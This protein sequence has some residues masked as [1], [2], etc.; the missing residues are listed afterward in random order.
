MLFLWAAILW[1][2]EAPST[3]SA[4][5]DVQS[6]KPEGRMVAVGNR[7]LH[8]NCTG[9]GSPTVIL[10]AGGGAY[11]IDW[12][13]VQ[14]SLAQHIR[15]C[16]YDRAGLAWSDPGPADETDE[17]TVSDLHTLLQNA[18]EKAPYVLVGASIGGSY[19]RAYQRS[20]PDEIAA[21]VFTNSSHRIGM[22]VNGKPGLIWNLSED[23]IRSIFPMPASSKP[24]KP[25]H[26]GEP[27]DRL[28]T[29][30]QG[31]RLSLDIQLWEKWSSSTAGPE[32]P[33]SWRKEFLREFD[34]MTQ[35]AKPV[36]G[37]LPVMVID[38]NPTANVSEC[39][40]RDSAAACLDFL[41]T[42]TAHVTATGSGHEIHLY[43]PDTVVRALFQVV[44]AVRNRTSLSGSAS[45]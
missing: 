42:N 45:Q 29:Q 37:A 20:F 39:Y 19:I 5:L 18:G 23:Q 22:S 35:G 38:S 33:L 27:F 9:Q 40:S 13:L 24:P 7:K 1:F 16:S 2:A 41:S 10:V 28:P 30:L 14:P 3:P 25:T 11:S 15:V 17:Q 21:L 34:E 6:Y 44:S 31:V 32:S 8:I 26:E 12:A 36:L 4:S 43:Q